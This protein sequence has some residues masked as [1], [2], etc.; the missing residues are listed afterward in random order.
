MKYVSILLAGVVLFSCNPSEQKSEKEMVKLNYPNTNKVDSVDTYFGTEIFDPYVWLEDD[1]SPETEAWVKE[2]N[3][4]TFSYLDKIPFSDK[5]KSRLE[6]KNIRVKFDNRD[7]FKPG[8]KFHEYELKGVPLRIAIGPKDLEKGTVEMARRDTLTKEIVETT[9]VVARVEGLL[10]EIQDNLF[11][12][13]I[14]Y[15]T[16]HTTQVSSYDEFKKVL[17]E[18]GGFISAHWDGTSETE[19]KIKKE[20]KA[21]IRCIPLDTDNQGGTCIVTGNISARKV[22]FAKAY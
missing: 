6:E 1:R 8:F 5:I 9:A 10:E 2:Q 22:L 20:T 12:K 14:N 18:K 4:L 7:K 19:D 11:A 3:E 16:A 13:A 17:N 21:T 15:R